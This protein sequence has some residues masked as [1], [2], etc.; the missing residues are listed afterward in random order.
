MPSNVS[1]AENCFKVHR[2]DC[3]MI[4]G[5]HFKGPFS[6]SC[7]RHQLNVLFYPRLPRSF[8]VS[9][10]LCL[11]LQSQIRH[12]NPERSAR[13]RA[14]RSC[15]I[16]FCSSWYQQ[17]L[18]SCFCDTHGRKAGLVVLIRSTFLSFGHREMINSWGLALA[19]L[20]L[21]PGPLDLVLIITCKS[22][23]AFQRHCRTTASGRVIVLQLDPTGSRTAA[24]RRTRRFPPSGI[25]CV[26][27][28]GFKV[29]LVLFSVSAPPWWAT[30]T[31]N[32]V[33]FINFYSP[34]TVK[35]QSTSTSNPQ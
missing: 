28:C 34:L 16:P 14:T 17:V 24:R 27:L 5:S 11:K 12:W 10:C 20:W 21:D 13:I 32:K 6:S 18:F 23:A 25:C 22:W 29:K 9:I 7:P 4:H 19:W 26:D 31:I 8:S 2:G 30:R 33:E 35:P 1:S 3:L 15:I